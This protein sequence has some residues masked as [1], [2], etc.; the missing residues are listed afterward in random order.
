[1][2]RPSRSS[3][4]HSF[5]LDGPTGKGFLR[6][7]GPRQGSAAEAAPERAAGPHDVG[8]HAVESPAQTPPRLAR[9]GRA[10]DGTSECRDVDNCQDI[11]HLH[12]RSS[13]AHGA[14]TSGD[15]SAA[16]AHVDRLSPISGMTEHS[17]MWPK[18]QAGC[19]Q[20]ADTKI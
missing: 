13:K 6:R 1:M 8:P 18:D 5:A 19:G 15:V 14:G 11:R 16:D 20:S 4:T 10:G 7:P 12:G 9:E 17:A 3:P 2:R